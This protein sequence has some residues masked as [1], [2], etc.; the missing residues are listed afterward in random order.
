MQ[1]YDI[2]LNVNPNWTR[3]AGHKESYEPNIW[4]LYAI[5][6]ALKLVKPLK[7]LKILNF[8]STQKG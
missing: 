1:K 7:L 4:L 6:A 8:E 3:S 2:P 5:T